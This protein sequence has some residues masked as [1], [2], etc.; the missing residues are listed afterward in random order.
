MNN[1][2]VLIFPKQSIA[3]YRYIF[4]PCHASQME[5]LMKKVNSF[6]LLIVF[7]KHYILNV[8]QGSQYASGLLK[9]I[10]FIPMYPHSKCHKKKW[11]ML[12]FTC[13]KLVMC[14]RAITCIKWRR[15]HLHYE[16]YIRV[17]N[18]FLPFIN[19]IKCKIR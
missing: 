14:T 8:W 10:F 1:I 13:I 12:F 11:S 19:G 7:A 6:Q 9:F 17:K 4:S 5:C 3:D 18:K 16:Q 2:S 15:L